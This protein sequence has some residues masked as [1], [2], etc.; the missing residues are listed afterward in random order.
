[1]VEMAASASASLVVRS[2]AAFVP[3]AGSWRN[4][5]F[6]APPPEVRERCRRVAVVEGLH[7]LAAPES[8]CKYSHQSGSGKAPA[9]Q[10]V[11]TGD[12]ARFDAREEHTERSVPNATGR[13]RAKSRRSAW[14]V[15]GWCSQVCRIEHRLFDEVQDGSIGP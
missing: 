7:L 9:P 4:E 11:L 10:D 13:D 1:M 6:G 12:V 2:L 15:G 3:G 5:T 8:R 14:G